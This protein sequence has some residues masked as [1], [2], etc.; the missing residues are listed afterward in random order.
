MSW[1]HDPAP[2]YA[3]SEGV[4]RRVLE[5][6]HRERTMTAL[7]PMRYLD[8]QTVTYSSFYNKA[9]AVSPLSLSRI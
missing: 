8:R 7:R 4:P 6:V 2:H 3:F 9:N 1:Q 5:E